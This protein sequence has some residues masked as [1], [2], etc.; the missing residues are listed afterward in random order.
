MR[1]ASCERNFVVIESAFMNE[2][3]RWGPVRLLLLLLV[4]LLLLL[5]ENEA[6]EAE[7]AE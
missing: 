1:A 2:A 5:R 7:L 3:L 6:R 4:L